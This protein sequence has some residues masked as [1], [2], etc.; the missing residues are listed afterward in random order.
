MTTQNTRQQ[1]LQRAL[2]EFIELSDADVATSVDRWCQQHSHLMPELGEM[3]TKYQRVAAAR[4]MAEKDPRLTT[5]HTPRQH[6]TTVQCPTC[7]ETLVIDDPEDEQLEVCPHCRTKLRIIEFPEDAVGRRLGRFELIECV[8]MGG[9]GYV[10]KARDMELDRVVALKLPQQT[11]GRDFDAIL[12]EAR[13]VA[14]LSHTNIVRVHETGTIEDTT[15]IVSDFIEG[16]TLSQWIEDATPAARQA[17]QVCIEIADA[18]DYAHNHGV[19]HRD[20]KPG[21]I[22]VSEE[23]KPHITDFGLAK[24]HVEDVTMTQDGRIIGTPAYMSPEQAMGLSSQTSPQSDIYSLG[25]VLFEMLT[26]E[27]PF[28]ARGGTLLRQVAEDDPIPPRQINNS[29]PRDLETICLK[30]L[31]KSPSQ[32]YQSAR[33]MAQ[34]LR[35]FLENRPIVARPTSLLERGMRFCQRRP[36]QAA[37]L[38]MTMLLLVVVATMGWR[39]YVHEKRANADLRAALDNEDRLRQFALST[40]TFAR[41]R[42]AVERVADDP[43]FLKRFSAAVESLDTQLEELAEPDIADDPDGHQTE[44]NF[45]R[46]HPQQ[47]ALNAWLQQAKQETDVFS[48]FVLGPHGNQIARAPRKATIGNNYS[49]RSYYH[50]GKQDFANRAAYEQSDGELLKKTYLSA[51]HTH[52]TREDVIAISTPIRVNGKFVGVVGLMI[53]LPSLSVD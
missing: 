8:G 42:D 35:N 17:V 24:L 9:F 39:F 20:L 28:R 30:C 14:K 5:D 13:I 38:F 1:A 37:T 40:A 6:Q 52:M 41:Y 16:S 44:R 25:V 19:T 48:W 22:L 51:L 46:K 7:H 12:R 2:D 47:K 21:N 34:D 10:W 4:R 23:G 11:T 36:G 3:L 32:R 49:R 29:I 31:R 45:V 15:F 43:E 27:L 26:Y 50:G 33:E 53:D 18:L